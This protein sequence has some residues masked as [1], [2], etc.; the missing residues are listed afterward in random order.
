[1][2]QQKI[3]HHSTLGFVSFCKN[4]K[5]FQ[6][7]F[8]I[9]FIKLTKAKF[10]NFY[11]VVTSKYNVGSTDCQIKEKWIHLPKHNSFMVLNGKELHELN[12]IIHECKTT[13]KLYNLFSQLN[14]SLN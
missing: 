2:S 3:L 10:Q 12:N 11:I 14:I 13:N 9:T 1:M 8:Y 4:C 7:A 5:H 6:I